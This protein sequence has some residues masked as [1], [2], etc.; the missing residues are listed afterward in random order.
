[1]TLLPTSLC[2][3]EFKTEVNKFKLYAITNAGEFVNRNSVYLSAH[4]MLH[5]SGQQFQYN[6][7]Q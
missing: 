2:S 7:Q 4:G 1:M 6:K 5:A 3:Y